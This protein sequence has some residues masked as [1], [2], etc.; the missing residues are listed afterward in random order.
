MVGSR[1]VQELDGGDPPWCVSRHHVQ[2]WIQADLTQPDC[3]MEDGEIAEAKAA[4]RFA[5]FAK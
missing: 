4:E 1:I 2:G 3:R 5:R